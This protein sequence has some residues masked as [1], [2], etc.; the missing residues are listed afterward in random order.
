MPLGSHS[1]GLPSRR[2]NF[3]P[4]FPSSL[5]R[6]ESKAEDQDNETKLFL[7]NCFESKAKDQDNETKLFYL[8]VLNL[9]QR[10]RLMKR[11]FFI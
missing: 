2:G 6:F 7:S 3:A 1:D 8:I 11:S 5:Q 10:I 9:K 4:H